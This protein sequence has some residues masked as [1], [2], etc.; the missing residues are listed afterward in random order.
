MTAEVFVVR[1][2]TCTNRMFRDA[3]PH[4]PVGLYVG[5]IR[6]R[7]DELSWLPMA[8]V[9]AESLSTYAEA[10][11][12]ELA[13]RKSVGFTF[14]I[15]RLA[16]PENPPAMYATHDVDL[17]EVDR[18][19]AASAASVHERIDGTDRALERV[20]KRL[21]A[22][23]RPPTEDE[24]QER[25]ARGML[26]AVLGLSPTPSWV[27]VERAIQKTIVSVDTQRRSLQIGSLVIKRLAARIRSHS[28]E[29]AGIVRQ[30]RSFEPGGGQ[31]VGTRPNLTPSWITRFDRWA[32]ELAETVAGIP[33]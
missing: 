9:A 14:E 7:R 25:L 29:L 31:H 10:V 23:F 17:V 19:L 20:A 2:V 16:E 12:L 3:D 32:S 30:W 5:N 24:E 11:E 26:G 15:V 13:A 6:W 8:L 33:E 28:D 18:V 22:V 4:N 1:V 21:R 27:E